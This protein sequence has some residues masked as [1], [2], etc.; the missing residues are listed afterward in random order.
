[1][2]FGSLVQELELPAPGS[3]GG[4]SDSGKSDIPAAEDR[5]D[6][7][8]GSVMGEKPTEPVVEPAAQQSAEL[9]KTEQPN[10]GPVDFVEA[11]RGAFI[12]QDGGIDS[13]RV[14]EFLSNK[15]KSFMQFATAPLDVAKAT[16]P[17]KLTPEKE[18]YDAVNSIAE[19]LPD[20]LEDE[21]AK[22]FTPKQTLQRL[23]N[24]LN[25]FKSQR[26]QKELMMAELEKSQSAFRSELEQVRDQKVQAQVDRNIAEMGGL[27]DGMIPGMKGAQVLDKF[28]LSPDYGGPMLERLF[29]RD[30]PDFGKVPEADRKGYTEKWFR[31]VQANRAD[32]ALIAEFGRAKWALE[33]LPNIAQH[34]KKIGAQLS[35][36]VQSTRGGQPSQIQAAPQKM[37]SGLSE[38]FGHDTVN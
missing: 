9:A 35:Q 25:G 20:I 16:E 31:N 33:Q 11:S 15:G 14:G 12:G 7:I 21:R 28:V 3:L 13:D 24:T 23:Q 32:L 2:D 19:T 5:V 27:L 4:E 30:N 22:G 38:F 36:A 17:V 26:E 37:S 1:M 8:L 34:G 18:Y 6:A 10:A 29:Q